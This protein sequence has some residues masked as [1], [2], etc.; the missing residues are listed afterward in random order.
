MIAVGATAELPARVDVVVVGAGAAGCVL[1]ARLSETPSTSVVLL[2]EG[3]ALTATAAEV[4]GADFL[5][6]LG[7]D[8]SVEGLLA[9]RVPGQ[10]ARPYGRGRGAGG[11][12]AVNAMVAMIAPPADYE[13]WER[14]HG[15]TGWGWAELAPVLHGLPVPRRQARRD[16]WGA[17]DEAL[18]QAAACTP[19]SLTRFA[20]GRRADAARI[21]L[22][23]VRHRPNLTVVG[24]AAVRRVLLDGW[25]AH[26]VELADGSTVA[27]ALVVLTAGAIGS[28]AI[29]LRS[30][31]E[32]WGIGRHLQD[33]ASC[34]VTLHLRR[35]APE[36]TLALATIATA[37]S[38]RADADLQLLPMNHLGPDAR[39][40]GLLSVALMTCRSRGR[41][42][43]DPV[44]P[45]G[46]PLVELGLLGDERDRADLAAGVARL[47]AVLAHEAWDRVAAEISIDDDGTP[48]TA[49]AD[50]PESVERWMLA[51]TG[52]YVH[53]AGTCRMGAPTDDG[54]VVDPSCQVIGYRGLAVC[55]ASIMPQL[56]R[57]NPMLTVYALAELASARLGASLAS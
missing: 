56:P 57:A 40:L 50:D 2:E 26:G 45:D 23:P 14:D 22:D 55:D 47:R 54:A 7:T 42:S 30:G 29:L 49:L 5:A 18:L 6:A 39:H 21:Y 36:G 20:D 34:P 15:C 8:R 43:L 17:V 52:D 25:R 44:D 33:H 37:T 4:T 9:T 46:P 51:R 24:D 13:A 16:E 3:P 38:G 48:L 32:R 27:A 12:T 28:P 10:P 1:A 11:S 19:A 41:L 35:P 31:I 53:A